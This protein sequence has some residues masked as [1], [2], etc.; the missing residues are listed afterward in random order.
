MYWRNNMIK[1]T[2]SPIAGNVTLSRDPE[3]ANVF[4][5]LSKDEEIGGVLYH[6]TPYSLGIDKHRKVVYIPTYQTWTSC[7]KRWNKAVE[8]FMHLQNYFNAHNIEYDV[9]MP[10]K[11]DIT[12]LKG[13]VYAYLL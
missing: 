5:G 12:N 9:E 6:L 2:L 10:K 4:Q 13:K 11:L 7:W 1:I 3:D 8:L